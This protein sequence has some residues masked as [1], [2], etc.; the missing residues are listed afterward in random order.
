MSMTETIKALVGAD[1]RMSS[2]YLFRKNRVGLRVN[3]NYDEELCQVLRFTTHFVAE[4]VQKEYLMAM[5]KAEVFVYDT[6]SKSGFVVVSGKH[7]EHY[8][9]FMLSP[10]EKYRQ[11][12]SATQAICNELADIE[13]EDEYKE[14]LDFLLKQWANIRQRKRIKI[15]NSNPFVETDGDDQD[16]KSPTELSIRLNPKAAKTGRPR[17]N[18][19]E[20]EAE[21]KKKRALFNESE[22]HRRKMGEVTESR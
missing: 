7:K 8:V 14:H 1:A 6:V 19:K 16:T 22:E 3:R 9:D 18:T 10:T 21:D 15:T 11:A 20:R 12:L 5:S 13:D 17:L 4:H 2:E